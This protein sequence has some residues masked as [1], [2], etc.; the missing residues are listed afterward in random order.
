MR[1]KAFVEVELVSDH[2]AVHRAFLNV[3]HI[4]GISP[5]NDHVTLISLSH[6]VTFYGKDYV[7]LPV[8]QMMGT[9]KRN[10]DLAVSPK[11]PFVSGG[12]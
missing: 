2:G 6:G 7:V 4:V 1:T 3:D 10:I 5:V 12:L 8:K 9:V 11:N